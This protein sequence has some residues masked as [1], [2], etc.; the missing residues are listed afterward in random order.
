M[1]ITATDPGGDSGSVDVIVD[2]S[3]VNER[4]SFTMGAG[5]AYAENARTR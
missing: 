4:P 3:D 5:G 2:V 1:R